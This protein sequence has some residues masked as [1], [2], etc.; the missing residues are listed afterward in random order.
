M[1]KLFLSKSFSKEQGLRNRPTVV[2]PRVPFLVYSVHVEITLQG[3]GWTVAVTQ[4][5]VMSLRLN[6]FNL[7]APSCQRTF[8]SGFKDS[9]G[10]TKFV[11]SAEVSEGR[12]GSFSEV[13]P[14]LPA[15]SALL[16]ADVIGFDQGVA[17]RAGRIYEKTYV[18]HVPSAGSFPNRHWR[19]GPSLRIIMHF[20][21]LEYDYSRSWLV[22]T[23]TCYLQD[24]IRPP[25]V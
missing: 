25:T 9:Q 22:C 2:I 17:N 20:R 5:W 6:S 8:I 18:H 1:Y 13:L 23:N 19:P 24:T 3:S 16:I 7:V 10:T 11:T 21:R 14:L 4:W 12:F 15:L